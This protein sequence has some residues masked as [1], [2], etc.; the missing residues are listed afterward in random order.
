MG[1]LIKTMIPFCLSWNRK[2]I[3]QVFSE[4]QNSNTTTTITTSKTTN[5]INKNNHEHVKTKPQQKLQQKQQRKSQRRQEAKIITIFLI[6]F[7]P[8]PCGGWFPPPHPNL[9]PFLFYFRSPS[10]LQFL[11]A[12]A[13]DVVHVVYVFLLFLLL[14]PPKQ[15]PNQNNRNKCNVA[16]HNN[17]AQKQPKQ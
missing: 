8:L 5:S 11:I 17:K 12:N 16:K 6:T 1:R 4:K 2:T 9:T 13:V 3:K 15:L 7:L 10:L 14:H